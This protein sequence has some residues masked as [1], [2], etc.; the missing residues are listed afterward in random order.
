MR[1]TCPP[2]ARV[3]ELGAAPGEQSVGLARAGYEVTAVDLGIASDAWEGA[4][5]GTM[6]RKFAAEGISFVE[7]NLEEAPYPLPDATFDAVVMTEVFEHLR[8]YPARSL[9]EVHRILRPGGHLYFTTPN[10]AYIGNRVRLA[11]G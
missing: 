9:T 3:V 5:E 2:P 7:W 10:A 8:D 1:S 4:A 11:R 6:E